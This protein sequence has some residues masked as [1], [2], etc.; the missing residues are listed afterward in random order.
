M[1]TNAKNKARPAFLI[2][3]TRNIER[4]NI[5]I[6]NPSALKEY[7]EIA[8]RV[9]NAANQY[10]QALNIKIHDRQLPY[11][12]L[13]AVPRREINNKSRVLLLADAVDNAIAYVGNDNEELSL[14]HFVCILIAMGNR[15]IRVGPRGAEGPTEI[16]INRDLRECVLIDMLLDIAM[17]NS[18]SFLKGGSLTDKQEFSFSKYRY[19]KEHALPC[20]FAYHGEED[21][22][23]SFAFSARRT[24]NTFDIDKYIQLWDGFI[25]SQFQSSI[26]MEKSL[27]EQLK[28]HVDYGHL[29]RSD[30][31][32]DLAARD[33]GAYLVLCIRKKDGSERVQS[34]FR[35]VFRGTK[36]GRYKIVP[37]E[38]IDDKGYKKMMMSLYISAFKVVKP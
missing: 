20:F 27:E 6:E 7:E 30:I 17:F 9:T 22:Y 36:I 8:Y 38:M 18:Y 32:K 35:S 25:K 24:T 15:D 12:K 19:H 21:L 37:I 5:V 31:L 4:R 11:V 28:Q 13:T 1:S 34:Q 10:I 33:K 26:H 23:Y 14:S 3:H 2:N 16:I 29:L